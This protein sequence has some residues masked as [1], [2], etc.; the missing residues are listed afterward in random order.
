MAG[1]IKGITVILHDR[2]ESGRDAFNAPIYTETETPVNNVLVSPMSSTEVLETLELTGA[3][4]VYQL[5][6]PKG[7]AHEWTTGKKVTFFG[8]DWRIIALPTQGIESMIPLDWNMKVQV[9][10]YG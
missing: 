4:A 6:I 8:E 7:D 1:I 5:G 2:I 9:E 3:R 10:R